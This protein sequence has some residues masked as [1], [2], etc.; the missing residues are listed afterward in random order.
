[1]VA[2]VVELVRDG[3][4][5]AGGSTKESVFPRYIALE[6]PDGSGKST[7]MNYLQQAFEAAGLPVLR[8]RDPGA[9]DVGK[10]IRE[11]LLTGNESKLDGM[12]EALLF[13]ADRRCTVRE[14]VRPALAEGTHVIADRTY[15]TT[16]VFQGYGR[17]LPLETLN[18]LT[19]VAVNETRPDLQVIL[20]LPVEVSLNRKAPQF[21]A[22]L[23]ESRFESIGSEF[24]RKN[25]EGYLLEA[26]KHPQ[27]Y[28]VVP[29]DGTPLE[30]HKRIVETINGRLAGL[31]L[32]PVEVV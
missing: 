28:A 30:V 32:K 18:M 22:G 13:S 27:T 26:A 11:I 9:T 1:M 12:T 31:N 10:K 29:A 25:R 2:D 20:D 17:G 8:V 14:L 5:M 4:M 16:L 24:H 3:L 23:D 6:G 21:Q 19:D 15:L 7:Q